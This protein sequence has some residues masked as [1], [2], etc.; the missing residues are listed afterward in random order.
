MSK[1]CAN[2]YT[3]NED[4][5]TKCKSCGNIFQNSESLSVEKS[6]TPVLVLTD[7]D[8][9]SDKVIRIDRSCTIGRKGEVET[10]FFAEDMYVSEYH[11]KIILKDDGFMIEHLPTAKNLTKINGTTLSKGMGLSIRDGEYLTIAD[12]VFEI[13]ICYDSVCEDNTSDIL[14]SVNNE[15]V[16][17]KTYFVIT[18]PKCGFE[19]EVQ[20]IDDSIDECSNCGDDYDKFEIS[21]IK[22]KV[23][24]AN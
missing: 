24:Y 22:A 12:K 17:E 23:R 14:A 10:D 6:S 2:C 7:M 1:E 21:K 18:C 8:K 5:A 20:N 3:N 15:A 13:S 19:Y 9:K 4:S 16:Y 11:C